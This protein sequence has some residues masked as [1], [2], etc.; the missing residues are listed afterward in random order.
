MASIPL[1]PSATWPKANSPISATF[2]KWAAS[3]ACAPPSPPS[4]PP[5]VDA[6]RWKCPH[7]GDPVFRTETRRLRQ[8]GVL[9]GF[10]PGFGREFPVGV[11]HDRGGGDRVRLRLSSA[12]IALLRDPGEQFSRTAP[13]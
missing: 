5:H 11:D 13:A 3:I 4:L 8:M 1:S 12:R 2:V 6:E 7:S 10:E 9:R